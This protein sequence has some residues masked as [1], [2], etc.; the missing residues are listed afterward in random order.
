MAENKK[1]EVELGHPEKDLKV[2]DSDNLPT[3]GIIMPIAEIDGLGEKHWAEVLEIL[4]DVATDAGF[5]TKLVSDADE[6]GIIQKRIVHNVYSNDIVIC[7]VS[8]KN[9]NVMF[10][11]GMR[12]AFDKAAIIVKDKTTSYSFD[13]SPIEHLLYPRDLRFADIIDFKKKLKDKLVATY[14]ASQK[15]NHSMYLKEFGPYKIAHLDEAEVSG[16]QVVL[17]SLED[18]RSQIRRNNNTGNNNALSRSVPD[19]H[20]AAIMEANKHAYFD[21]YVKRFEQEKGKPY[22]DLIEQFYPYLLDRKVF[23]DLFPSTEAAENFI[24]DKLF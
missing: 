22:T 6:V 2:V 15:T 20:K 7:D 8:A 1:K 3:C 19:R 18:L 17:E 14:K 24:T 16:Y 9:P 11:L 21:A 13:T 4:I 12:L 23:T 5:K 10:E